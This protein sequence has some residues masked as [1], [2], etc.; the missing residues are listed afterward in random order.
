VW[1]PAKVVGVII[2]MMVLLPMFA[3]A[4]SNVA[5]PNMQP[6][7]PSGGFMFLTND[8][9]NTV[10]GVFDYFFPDTRFEDCAFRLSVGEWTFGTEGV[11]VDQPIHLYSMSYHV[12]VRF[13]DHDLDGYFTSWDY[14]TVYSGDPLSGL[15][16]GIEIYFEP[17]GERI[18]IGWISFP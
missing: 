13:V 3:Y 2:A 6:T 10:R 7:T 8:D 9:N 14:C 5:R 11:T 15:Q 18:C 16:C 4:I 17:T 12:E 1:T